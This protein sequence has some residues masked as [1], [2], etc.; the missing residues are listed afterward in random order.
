MKKYILISTLLI[1]QIALAATSLDVH[2]S[3]VE[4]LGE[5]VTGQHSGDI[6]LKKGEVDIEDGQLNGGSFVFDMKSI[7][8]LDIK[9]QK[10]NKKLEAHL[11]DDDFFGVSSYPY[12]V[13]EIT[14]AQPL[15]KVGDMAENYD[16][17]GEL[18][19]KGITHAVSFK[20]RVDIK[21]RFSKAS[22]T[23]MVDRTRYGIKYKSGK[24]FEGLGDRAIYD[25]FAIS[26]E[27]VTK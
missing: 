2:K 22:G 4:W 6:K 19:I 17:K 15:K 12:S 11:K 23:I 3:Q 13:F 21:P 27:V 1:S 7:R 25:D 10:W 26:F 14:S 9:D 8:V 20:A 18:T 16:I 5:K 24:F